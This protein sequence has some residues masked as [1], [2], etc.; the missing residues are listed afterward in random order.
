MG[1]FV[2][3]YSVYFPFISLAVS[4]AAA[5]R[6]GQQQPPR[7][8]CART[9]GGWRKGWCGARDRIFLVRAIT[10]NNPLFP[11]LPPRTAP[12]RPGR[13]RLIEGRRPGGPEPLH[14][15]QT[16]TPRRRLR[17]DKYLSPLLLFLSRGG[18]GRGAARALLAGWPSRRIPPSRRLYDRCS[19]WR[20]GGR[21]GTAYYISKAAHH[22]RPGLLA[23]LPI[24][25]PP[26]HRRRCR[27]RHC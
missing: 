12:A 18:A 16:A 19:Q 21:P 10:P 27:R 15:H 22:F 9:S 11:A 25:A 6:W 7:R 2:Q 5:A 8:R 13:G 26:H 23:P 24:P 4:A 14:A 17:G 3:N 1:G 20:R